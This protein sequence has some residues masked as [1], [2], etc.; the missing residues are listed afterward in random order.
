MAKA[1][2]ALRASFTTCPTIANAWNLPTISKSTQEIAI[3]GKV[4]DDQLHITAVMA[5]VRVKESFDN[6]NL[7]DRLKDALPKSAHVR[8]FELWVTR[9]APIAIS[10]GGNFMKNKA[11]GDDSWNL[12]AAFASPFWIAETKKA[13]EKVIELKT[14]LTQLRSLGKRA[15]QLSP[16]DQDRFNAIL[17]TKIDLVSEA[18]DSI[19]NP[20]PMTIK[21]AIDSVIESRIA[22]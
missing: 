8:A 5:L 3:A 13:A 7:L 4:L 6:I 10:E 17:G 15:K 12:D 18:I 16:S 19:M 2:N 20:K 14:L 1:T 21:Q 11:K 22:A 9:H